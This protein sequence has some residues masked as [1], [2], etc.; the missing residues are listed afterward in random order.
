MI[1]IKFYCSRR[2]LM[3]NSQYTK[4]QLEIINEKTPLETIGTKTAIALYEKAIKNN[5]IVLAEKVRTRIETSKEEA[6]ERNRVRARN[7]HRLIRAQGISEWHEWKQPKSNEYTEHQRQIVRGEIPL[8]NVHTNEL[9]HIQLKAQNNQ[10][11]ELAERF[12]DIILARRVAAREKK[13][14]RDRERETIG[15]NYNFD[16]DRANSKG[17]TRFQFG[18]LNGHIN[19][20]EC[21]EK[22]LIDMMNKFSTQGNE[23][24]LDTV[25][26][27]LQYKRDPR[28]IY[29]TQ[30]HWEAIDMIENMV[31]IPIRR[32]STWFIEMSE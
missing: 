6:L 14:V 29:I 25:Q 17:L 12:M 26:Q 30:D 8:D 16:W 31:Q 4:K 9:I 13:L 20:D 3:S 5:D 28:A 1:L 2:S 10:D 18:V 11:F 7:R 32:P 21:S 27:L 22:I 23:T 15:I 24:W 19:L